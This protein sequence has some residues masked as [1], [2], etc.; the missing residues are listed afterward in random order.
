[1]E[2]LPYT[3]SQ[4]STFYTNTNCIQ[5][6]LGFTCYTEN[7]LAAFY[8]LGFLFLVIHINS[9]VFPLSLELGA[10]NKALVLTWTV[11]FESYLCTLVFGP[12]KSL[13]VLGLEFPRPVVRLV[14]WRG[15]PGLCFQVLIFTFAVFLTV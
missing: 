8:M 7:F 14:E 13:T 9:F 2:I 4:H 5:I 3:E 6:D 1:M 15:Q 12:K 11:C 10:L